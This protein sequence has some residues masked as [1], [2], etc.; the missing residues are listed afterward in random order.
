MRL[1]RQNVIECWLHSERGCSVCES[2]THYRQQYEHL[3]AHW[4]AKLWAGVGGTAHAL[5]R[6]LAQLREVCAVSISK[7]TNQV[8]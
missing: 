6:S 3:M 7:L 1:A 2:A 8:T 5:Q 4:I